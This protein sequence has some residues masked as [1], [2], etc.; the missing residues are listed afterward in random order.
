MIGNSLTQVRR[1]RLA[2]VISAIF[3]A[4]V[5]DN[6]CALT[7]LVTDCSDGQSSGT[8]RN[9]IAAAP[10]N[11]IVQIPLTCSKITLTQGHIFIPSAFHSL[12][13]VGQGPAA[14][15]ID[16]GSMSTPAVHDVAF[17]SQQSEM[18][19]FSQLTITHASPNTNT[20]KGGCVSSVIGSVGLNH[21]V[22]SGCN[23]SPADADEPSKGGG[24][25]AEG[26]VSLIDS[27]VSDNKAIGAPGQASLGGGIYAR[28]G[29][30][31]LRSTITGNV[32]QSTFATSG[33][34][35]GGAY[36]GGC[37]NSVITRSTI[38]NNTANFNSALDV[39]A[40][41]SGQY[42]VAVNSSTIS[43]N[44]AGEMTVGTEVTTTVTNSTIA[45][46]RVNLTDTT[47]PAGLFSTHQIVMYNSIF[48][49]NTSTAGMPNDVYSTVFSPFPFYGSNNLITSS[50]AT[51]LPSGTLTSCPKLGHL[52]SNGGPTQ[53]IPLLTGSPALDAG[54]PNGQT[55]D[56][57]G[58]GFPRSVGAG[59][60]IGAY[61]R[62]S[63]VV[64]DVIFFGQFEGRCD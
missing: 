30:N 33:S 11:S 35:G 21:A 53:T 49:N 48:A 20:W 41:V 32:A 15:V 23:L 38:S 36:S 9:T 16:G 51:T 54:M 8:L 63:G 25:Y 45:F 37:G 42:T 10:D 47:V 61:E 64:D 34:R 1:L 44:D 55:T 40:C 17:Y 59:A 14:T 46:N 4:A 58:A 22:V 52:S 28:A 29:V 27:T 3:G 7:L 60:D 6:V 19:G 12:Y 39:V 5:S 13:I 24:V 2:L 26:S 31:A 57:R 50:S 62:Q 43:G 18:L 56:Q